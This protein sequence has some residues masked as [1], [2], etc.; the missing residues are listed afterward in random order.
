MKVKKRRGTNQYRVYVLYLFYLDIL[1][2]C[3]YVE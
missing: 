2:F 1:I 3:V